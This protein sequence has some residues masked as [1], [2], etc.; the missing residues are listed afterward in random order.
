MRHVEKTLN[1][2]FTLD[3]GAASEPGCDEQ[4]NSTFEE[5]NVGIKRMALLFL[6]EV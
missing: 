5:P 4:K 6:G 1:M 2:S 3:V